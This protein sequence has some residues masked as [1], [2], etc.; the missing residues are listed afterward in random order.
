MIDYDDSTH[1]Y[2]YRGR[3]YLSATQVIEYFS[4]QFDTDQ[5]AEEH[6]YRH[7]MTKEHWIEDWDNTRDQALERGNRIHNLREEI[8]RARGMDVAFGIP[9]VVRN[10]NL[11]PEG[12]LTN[13]PDGIYPELK[14]WSHKWGVAGR[15]DKVVFKTVDA[16]SQVTDWSGWSPSILNDYNIRTASIQDYKSNRF[17]RTRGWLNKDGSRQMMKYPLEHLEDCAMVHYELQLSEY[18]VMLEEHGYSVGFREIIHFPHRFKFALPD[19]P[20]PPPVAYSL[21]YRRDDVLSMWTYLK[22]RGI[23]AT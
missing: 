1:T 18:Q 3:R 13:L 11:Y 10:I 12:Q 23:L 14:V 7:G 2:S 16:K 8:V 22:Q 4:H 6:A 20:D 15:S 5:R 21:K 19:W 9:M 17:I